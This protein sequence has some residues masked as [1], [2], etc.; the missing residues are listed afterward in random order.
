MHAVI[1]VKLLRVICN[2]ILCLCTEKRRLELIPEELC[3]QFTQVLQDT[4]L[5]DLHK[6]LEDFRQD[7]HNC[8]YNNDFT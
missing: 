6:N 5:P 8:I 3:K 7:S 1:S 4:L 2:D